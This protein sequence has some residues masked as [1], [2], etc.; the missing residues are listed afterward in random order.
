M[1]RQDEMYSVNEN[2]SQQ[3]QNISTLVQHCTNVIKQ[4]QMLYKCFVFDGMIVGKIYKGL[5][6]TRGCPLK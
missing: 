3:T 1:L 2:V 4:Q 6:A 5:M